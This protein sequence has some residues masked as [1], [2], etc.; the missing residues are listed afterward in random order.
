MSMSNGV[1]RILSGLVYLRF[2]VRSGKVGVSMCQRASQRAKSGTP[3]AVEDGGF[4]GVAERGSEGQRTQ[5]M[6]RDELDT[7]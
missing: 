6:D 3:A 2:A 7:L 5:F 4:V 1:F